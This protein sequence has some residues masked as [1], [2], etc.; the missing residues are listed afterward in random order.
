VGDVYAVLANIDC[1]SSAF[2]WLVLEQV[3]AAC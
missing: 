3:R 1:R 2:A